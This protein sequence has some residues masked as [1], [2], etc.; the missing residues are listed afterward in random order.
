MTLFFFECCLNN[1]YRCLPFD[2]LKTTTHSEFRERI[3]KHLIKYSEA[4]FPETN[5]NPVNFKKPLIVKL[6]TKKDVL[7][8]N[9]SKKVKDTPLKSWVCEDC[10]ETFCFTDCFHCFHSN[11]DSIYVE[12]VDFTSTDS[13]DQAN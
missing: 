7:L 13:Y 4:V 10:K 12:K 9:H 3:T 6:E 11:N 1:S 8:K 5:K 2:I